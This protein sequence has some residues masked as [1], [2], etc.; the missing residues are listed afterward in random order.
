MTMRCK[1]LLSVLL[2]L[3]AASAYAQFGASIQGTVVDASGGAVAGA[4]VTVTNPDTGASKV[5][6]TNDT[7][8]YRVSALVPGK[9]TITVEAPGFK[10]DVTN[11]VFVSAEELT[12]HDIVVEPGTVTESVN[13]SADAVTL[14][15]ENANVGGAITAE[16]I[17]RLPEIGRDPYELL[18]LAPG[19]LGD[20]ARGG[21]T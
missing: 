4:T 1:L 8:F 13:V 12:G 17:Q 16:E 9:Y 19:V 15:S 5:A 20:N 6:I 7:G 14:N 2:S 10:K 18:R 21:A 3:C 11:G